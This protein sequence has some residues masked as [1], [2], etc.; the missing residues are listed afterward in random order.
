MLIEFW[1][2]FHLVYDTFSISDVFSIFRARFTSFDPR[3]SL[4]T[5]FVCF[6]ALFHSCC[7]HARV[8]E[9]T[10]AWVPYFL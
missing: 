4:L 5:V 3:A 1:C 7:S 10:R 9:N 8:L 6:F 2:F